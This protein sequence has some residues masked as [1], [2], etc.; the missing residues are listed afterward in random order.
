MLL[1]FALS[2]VVILTVAASG[3]IV[4][5]AIF[6]CLCVLTSAPLL[7]PIAA[8]PCTPGRFRVKPGPR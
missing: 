5:A 4:Q 3:E 2:F 7:L 6:L 1:L 8:A